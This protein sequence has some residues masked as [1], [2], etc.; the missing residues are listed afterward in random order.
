[1]RKIFKYHLPIA[2]PTVIVAMPNN[3]KILS[4]GNQNEQVMVWADVEEDNQLEDHLFFIRGTGHPM[5]SQ[6]STFI[7]TV[8][9]AGG[10]LVWHIFHGGRA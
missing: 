4:A 10:S 6:E 8:I 2:G 3:P 7:D 1:M 5:H 9:V